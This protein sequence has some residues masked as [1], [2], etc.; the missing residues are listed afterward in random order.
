MVAAEIAHR[1]GKGSAKSEVR[2]KNEGRG[3]PVTLAGSRAERRNAPMN[4]KGMKSPANL[5][6]LL[7]LLFK[8][9]RTI[10]V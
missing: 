9:E 1:L 2:G 10:V 7:W 6:M 8:L 4:R 5:L 3:P